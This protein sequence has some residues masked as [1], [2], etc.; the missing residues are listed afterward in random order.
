MLNHDEEKLNHL[1]KEAFDKALDLVEVPSEKEEWN[2]F[3]VKY[4]DILFTDHEEQDLFGLF[5]QKDLRDQEENKTV[6]LIKPQETKDNKQKQDPFWGKHLRNVAVACI[7]LAVLSFVIAKPKTASAMGEWIIKFFTKKTGETTEMLQGSVTRN[8]QNVEG[9]YVE[10]ERVEATLEEAQNI[11]SFEIQLPQYLPFVPQDRKIFYL[12]AVD[13]VSIE[14]EYYV[15]EKLMLTIM[16]KKIGNEYAY[17]VAYDTDDTQ[18]EEISIKNNNAHVFTF[19]N[20]VSKVI[21]NQDNMM[22][23]LQG[24]MNKEDIIKTAE[25]LK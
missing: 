13:F 15:E 25:S 5:E 6:Y 22:Y 2:K 4:G 7:F 21:W 14:L 10:H 12:K 3:Q 19:K 11:C 16:Q 24:K 23:E 17:T 1:I 18:V 8:Y 20:S 9:G